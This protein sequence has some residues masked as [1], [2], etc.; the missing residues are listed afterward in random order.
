M[1]QQ[2]EQQ[3]PIDPIPPITHGFAEPLTSAHQWDFL[4][5]DTPFSDPL[6]EVHPEEE[7]EEADSQEAE[8]EDSRAEET[9]EDMALSKEIHKEDH[10]GTD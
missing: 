1:Q 7:A 10:Q 9:Q 8:E 2:Q 4:H 3:G 5:Q 6:V